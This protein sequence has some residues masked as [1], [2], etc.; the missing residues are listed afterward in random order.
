[1][2]STPTVTRAREILGRKLD[3]FRAQE[4]RDARMRQKIRAHEIAEPRLVEP[5]LIGVALGD[6]RHGFRKIACLG[7]LLG[8]REH[9][10]DLLLGRGCR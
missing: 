9:G 4:K 10:A 5:V 3:G 8:R 7:L 6:E 1:M 2:P